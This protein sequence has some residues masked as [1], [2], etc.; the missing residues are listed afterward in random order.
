MEEKRICRICLE[1]NIG[2]IVND[3]FLAALIRPCDC[4]G[5]IALV[6]RSCLNTWRREGRGAHDMTQCGVCLA[7]YQ[8]QEKRQ[9]EDALT[10]FWKATL[11]EI[12]V[13]VLCMAAL[14]LLGSRA[15]LAWPTLL[16]FLSREYLLENGSVLQWQDQLVLG[17]TVAA[18]V[19][20]VIGIFYALV[21]LSKSLCVHHAP[22]TAPSK[23]RAVD[24]DAMH[25]ESYH[26]RHVPRHVYHH[27]LFH[28]DCVCN[29]CCRTG[30][31]GSRSSSGS[32]NNG[33]SKDTCAFI[34]IG[35]LLLACAV[36][37]AW[38]LYGWIRIVVDR[39]RV[40]IRQSQIEALVV[41]DRGPIM[42]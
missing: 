29:G 37:V 21:H 26:T 24:F 22:P 28:D 40:A 20:G 1:E 41:Q 4:R 27:H 12:A 30:S 42:N 32:S 15:A 10:L 33:S 8:F 35:F 7:Y 2:D 9:H 34:C 36:F 6:H 11:Q 39:R 5:G 19:T 25:Y 3:P 16:A 13:A 17:G 18:I 14:V 23:S 38:L 31:S